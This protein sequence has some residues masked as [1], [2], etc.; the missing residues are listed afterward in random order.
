MSSLL[1]L[2]ITFGALFM[3]PQTPDSTITNADGTRFTYRHFPSRFVEPRTIEVWVPQA[4]TAGGDTEHFAVLYMQDG[5]N[6]F[7][8]KESAWGK[9]WEIDKTMARLMREKQIRKSILVGIRSTHVRERE[10]QPQA[11]YEIFDDSLRESFD[12]KYG[13]PPLSDNYLRFLVEEVK[14]FVDAQYRTLPD[15][16]NTFVIGSSRGGLISLYALERYPG[17]FSGAAC[18][19]THWPVHTHV[20]IPAFGNTMVRYFGSQL[21]DPAQVKIYF[22]FGTATLD[23]WYEPY[24]TMMDTIMARTG[25]TPGKN[26]MTKKFPGAEHDERAWSKRVAIPLQFLLT[27]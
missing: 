24:Q 15:R 12:K 20:N 10:Y 9:V 14:P 19:S 8:L 23:A 26:W 11:A 4:Y 16:N 1:T 3:P 17:V 27:P 13:G 18:I 22:D 7:E 6:L 25:F 21:P 2:L 5:Q